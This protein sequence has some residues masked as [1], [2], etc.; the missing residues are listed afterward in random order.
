MN[1]SFPK[2]KT[3][4]LL[5]LLVL[6]WQ[7]PALAQ[8]QELPSF[9]LTNGQAFS[10][11]NA[12]DSLSVSSVGTVQCRRSRGGLSIEVVAKDPSFFA[13]DNATLRQLLEDVLTAWAAACAQANE[14][15]LSDRIFLKG[16]GA[17]RAPLVTAS[18]QSGSFRRWVLGKDHPVMR[19]QQSRL[20]ELIATYPSLEERDI[21]LID[22]R[23]DIDLDAI[24]QFVDRVS[25]QRI[26]SIF[27]ALEMADGI[28][29]ACRLLLGSYGS[30]FQLNE[31][32]IEELV[33]IAAQI[34]PG[35]SEALDEG[36]KNSSAR[37]WKIAAQ[38]FGAEL[39]RR[40]RA[41]AEETECSGPEL[42]G[43]RQF[44]ANVSA[45]DPKGLSEW[46]ETVSLD[47]MAFALAPAPKGEPETPKAAE[48]QSVSVSRRESA[49]AVLA[50]PPEIARSFQIAQWEGSAVVGGVGILKGDGPFPSDCGRA[51]TRGVRTTCFASEHELGAAAFE[52]LHRFRRNALAAGGLEVLLPESAPRKQRNVKPDWLSERELSELLTEKV[53]NEVMVKYLN[54][55]TLPQDPAAR[56]NSWQRLRNDIF[57]SLLAWAKRLPDDF[58]IFSNIRLGDYDEEAGYYGIYAQSRWFPGQFYIPD[59]GLVE[60]YRPDRSRIRLVMDAGTA[61]ALFQATAKKRAILAERVRYDYVE[62]GDFLRHGAVTEQRVYTDL[63]LRT[64]DFVAQVP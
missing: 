64:A 50:E 19:Q 6:L 16:L 42:V 34:T 54:N 49:V 27:E 1:G 31:N 11:N 3:L 29:S 60:H 48:Q 55:W 58:W 45:L 17:G 9:S 47:P 41:F 28:Q 56:E 59:R 57:P 18:Y 53:R 36:R 51:R 2:R 40:A 15:M 37:S 12:N 5:P 63:E 46:M 7:L 35:L 24:E 43:V 4:V 32:I 21:E 26:L 61:S 38:E 10:V 62:T 8:A 25:A 52:A 22:E 44:Y 30:Y 23:S 20:E 33:L 14:R 39:A 13:Q